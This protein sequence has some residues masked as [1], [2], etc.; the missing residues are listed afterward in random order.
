MTLQRSLVIVL[1]MIVLILLWMLQNP[2]E[3]TTHFL[4]FTFKISFSSLLYIL[5]FYGAIIGVFM[6][7]P[8]LRNKNNIIDDLSEKLESI[9]EVERQR[10]EE[11]LGTKN[12][13]EQ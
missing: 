13:T 6:V 1:S 12:K 11:E 2:I 8:I 10:V 3:V 9:R 5:V 7:W 4:F